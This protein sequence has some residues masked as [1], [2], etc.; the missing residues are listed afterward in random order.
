MTRRAEMRQDAARF[1]KI[2][3]KFATKAWLKFP[4]FVLTVHLP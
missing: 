4:I 1:G 3:H 2:R